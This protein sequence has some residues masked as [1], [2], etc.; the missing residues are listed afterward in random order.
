MDYKG[1][2]LRFNVRWLV[3][4]R[5]HN[6]AVGVFKHGQMIAPCADIYLAQRW[7]DQRIKTEGRMARERGKEGSERDTKRAKGV[8]KRPNRGV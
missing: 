1:F 5:T 4:G 2:E 6:A 7:V 8:R 3:R